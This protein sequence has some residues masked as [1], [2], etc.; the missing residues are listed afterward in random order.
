MGKVWFSKW[1]GEAFAM[2]VQVGPLSG[3]A[4]VSSY[5]GPDIAAKG[6]SVY[7][8][9]KQLPEDKEHIYIRHSYDGGV[10]FS[11][12]EVAV[13]PDGNIAR[14]PSLAVDESGAPFLSFMKM[15]RGYDGQQHYVTRSE[16]MGESFIGETL[17]SVNTG[18]KVCECS[19]ANLVVSGNAAV[20][21]YRNYIGGL[22][23]VWAAVS[24]NG[25]KSFTAAFQFDSA[26]F[27]PETCPA[28]APHGTI[29][30][31]TLYAVYASGEGAAGLV[32]I[33]KFSLSTSTVITTELTGAI[34]GIVMQHLPRICGYGAAAAVVWT[35][36]AGGNAQVALSFTDDI[37]HGF[38]TQYDTVAQGIMMNADVA[39]GGGFIYIVWEDQISHRV[40]FRKG[41][42]IRRRADEEKTSVMVNPPKDGQK[43]FT[44]IMQDIVSCAL[45]DANGNQVEMDISYP[46]NKDVCKVATDDMEPG[47][48]VVRVWDKDGKMYAAR[49]E[50]K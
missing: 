19:P 40:M 16:D 27:K 23:N 14:Y 44:V 35:Q 38:P 12:R 45:I 37:T 43:Y 32:Y 20:L 28:S 36:T 6:D 50:L 29:L 4:F 11:A 41:L 39:I 1:G 26:A 47:Q 48:Y 13:H 5:A 8:V 21:L 3:D 49:V 46:K 24:M 42:Y 33:S 15:D 31:D 18:G 10:H 34:P 30:A 7:I 22:R 2:P 25:G 9:Y 17:G